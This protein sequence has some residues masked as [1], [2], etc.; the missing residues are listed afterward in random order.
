MTKRQNIAL[1][2]NIA[3]FVFGC[4]GIIFRLANTGISDFFLYYTQIS[5]VI[6]VISSAI[7]I[8][9]R[10]S[11]DRNVIVFMKCS[12]YLSACM[13]T[14]TFIVVMC[15]F[16]PMSGGAVTGRLL[17]SVNGMMHHAVCPVISVASYIFFEDGVK[18]RKAL[19][20][21]FIATAIYAGVVYTLNFLRL[22]KAP[23]PFFEVY[24]HPVIE[25]IIWFIG[26]ML[27]ITAIAAVVR[28]ANIA[29]S[30]KA[31]RRIAK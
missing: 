10:K 8:A 15:L 4:V 29:A 19:L 14:M 13:L 30:K 23:Y 18:S 5:N 11:E 22:A 28:I 21:P 2:L 24:E 1:I 7:F 16:I 17:G 26:L 27:L 6:A 12:R 31:E 25:L 9:V 3:A 20:I